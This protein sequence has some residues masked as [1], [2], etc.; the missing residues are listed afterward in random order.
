MARTFAAG[1]RGSHQVAGELSDDALELFARAR[2]NLYLG[3]ADQDRLLADLVAAYRAGSR[4][5]WGPVILDLLAPAL[6]QLL[7]ELRPV[8]PLIDEDEIR[9]Q[10]V[11]EVLRAAAKIPIRDSFDMKFR[12][13][14]RACKP[15]V[16][17]LTREGHR[18]RNQASYEALREREQ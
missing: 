1:L 9:Q 17:W 18:Q 2:D 3:R 5:L 6:V 14:S 10:L 8:P 15:I 13:I 11:L 7:R 12:L 4:Q 16:R